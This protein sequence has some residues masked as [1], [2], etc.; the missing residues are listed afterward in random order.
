MMGIQPLHEGNE[1]TA[2]AVD[3]KKYIGPTSVFL[4]KL[5]F[6]KAITIKRAECDQQDCV[7]KPT[8]VI[9]LCLWKRQFI[10]FSSAW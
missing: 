8:R 7:S 6:L 5:K 1:E 9:L 3:G 10:A 2:V 4:C